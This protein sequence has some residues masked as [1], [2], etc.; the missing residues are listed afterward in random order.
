MYGIQEKTS[1]LN[2]GDP[3]LRAKAAKTGERQSATD[4]RR[5]GS[6][7]FREIDSAASG[8]V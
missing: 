3:T 7:R 6:V 1:P 2:C 4:D 8:L 5:S